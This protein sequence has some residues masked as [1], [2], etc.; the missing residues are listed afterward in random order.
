M[1]MI[2]N[3]FLFGVGGAEPSGLDLHVIFGAD[4]EDDD[5]RSGWSSN[6]GLSLASGVSGADGVVYQVTSGGVPN[7]VIANET[8]VSAYVRF[9]PTIDATGDAIMLRSA[10]TTEQCRV[11][12][13]DDGAIEVMSGAT[14]LRKSAT[15]LWVIDTWYDVMFKA[16]VDDSGSFTVRMW[17]AGSLVEDHTASADTKNSA[18]AGVERVD[19]GNTANDSHMDNIA[20]D[21]GGYEF[22]PSKV[23]VRM[24]T[25]NSALAPEWPRTGTDS[26]ANFS[27]VNE[28]PAT[29]THHL[30]SSG[31]GQRD[32]Y[33]ISLASL[34]GAML[35]LQVNVVGRRDTGG[36]NPAQFNHALRI[37]GVIYEGA[38]KDFTSGSA[39]TN[40]F[41]VWSNNPATGFAWDGS[42]TVEIGMVSVTDSVRAHQVCASIFVEL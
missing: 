42:E 21:L 32:F 19:Y 25:G 28:N 12:F 40:L 35:A 29:F 16:F 26:G 5:A 20:V 37:G 27:Q 7:I 10:G 9:R 38:T 24:P 17:D 39:D 2:I 33:P 1:S 4:H 34:G 14:S 30:T 11:R 31:V 8:T 23:I 18:S 3:P 13:V 6:T 41:H 36:A 15:G 22:V